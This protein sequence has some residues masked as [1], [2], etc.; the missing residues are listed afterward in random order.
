MQKANVSR[1][2]FTAAKGSLM[3]LL[4][5]A[6]LVGG[7][8][9]AAYRAM[10][11]QPPQATSSQIMPVNATPGAT[12]GIDRE[13]AELGVMAINEVRSAAFRLKNTGTQPVE[14]SQVRTSCM[15]AFAEIALPDSTSPEFSMAMHNDA[16]ANAWRGVLAPGEEAVVTVTYKPSLMPVEGSVAR[17]VKFATTDPQNPIVELGV[18]ATVTG[19]A[20]G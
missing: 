15:C 4:V 14:I 2:T 11:P 20:A 17:N 3:S 8:A 1:S 7:V 12:L 18:H 6:V 19:G 9:T 10:A 5:G 13:E 16:A